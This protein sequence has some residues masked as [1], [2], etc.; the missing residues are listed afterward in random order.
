MHLKECREFI[1]SDFARLS[2][3]KFKFSSFFKMFLFQPT[4]RY[5]FFFRV[6]NCFSKLH[7]FGLLGRLWYYRMKGKFGLQI[8]LKAKIGMGYCL[9][10]FGNIIINQGAVFGDNCN[11]SQRGDNWEYK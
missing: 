10:H 7:P 4:F 6:N 2:K 1:K 11:V 9:N 5:L 3:K 8:F